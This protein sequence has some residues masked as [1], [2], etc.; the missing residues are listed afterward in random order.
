MQNLFSIEAEELAMLKEEIKKILFLSLKKEFFEVEQEVAR[1]ALAADGEEV[2]FESLDLEVTQ[3]TKAHFGHY[4]CNSAMMLA[5]RWRLPPVEI[6]RRWCARLER[7]E[8]AALFSSITVAGPG[9]I[10]LTLAQEALAQRLAR[11]DWR[12]S[13]NDPEADFAIIDYSSPNIA[14][15]MHVGHLR[16]TIIGES[17]KRMLQFTGWRVEGVN[18]VGDWG[19]QFGMLIT[20]LLE[21]VDPF[22]LWLEESTIPTMDQEQVEEALGQLMAWYRAARAHFTQDAQFAQRSKEAVVKLQGGDR[23]LLAI[24]SSICEIS[25]RDFSQIYALLGVDLIERGES[26]YRDQLEPMTRALEDEGLA[27]R[28]EGALCIFIEGREVPVMLQKSD[29][30][31][32]YDTTDL[33]ALA[34]RCLKRQAKR[35]IYVT[36]AGQGLHFELIFAAGRAA[37]FVEQQELVHIPFGLVLGKDGKKFKTRDGETEK[38]KDLLQEAVTRALSLVKER[39]DGGEETE[40]MHRARCLG[41]GAVKYADLSTDRTGDYRFSY[42]KMLSFE[43]NTAVFLMYSLVRA[44][45][46]LQKLAQ[47]GLERE[48]IIKASFVLTHESEERLALKLLQFP[49]ALGAALDGFYP[50]RLADYLYQVATGFNQFFRDCRV[51]GDAQ[52]RAR[53]HLVLRSEEVLYLGLDL[54]GIEAVDRM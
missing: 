17:I 34:D 53:A 38:L 50:H 48:E 9:F 27:K 24:W 15:Q 5:R 8:G 36:D 13:C 23:E 52:E 28:S 22:P 44:R 47:K 12:A 21:K 29:G 31:F 54:L 18:H 20:F 11:I 2:L 45:S 35:L 41:I 3:A 6:A 51:E 39:E 43:G 26:F 4:Q 16:S 42:E 7:E 32:N 19:T 40:L 1:R 49:E 33:A 14:K 30:G 46:I 25:R 37:G 10:N